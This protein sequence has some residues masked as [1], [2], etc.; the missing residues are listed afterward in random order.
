MTRAKWG[1]QVHQRFLRVR[2]Q[3]RLIQS[4]DG[5]MRRL[6]S[7]PGQPMPEVGVNT[8][9][10]LQPPGPGHALH[11]R[12]HQDQQDD[13]VQPRSFSGGNF[14]QAQGNMSVKDDHSI[15]RFPPGC[16]PFQPKD[17]PGRLNSMGGFILSC[18]EQRRI[19]SSYLYRPANSGG[20]NRKPFP[21][22]LLPHGPT[23]ANRRLG[24]MTRRISLPGADL[25][26]KF[27]LWIF[28]TDYGFNPG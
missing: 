4:H 24:G 25:Q 9:R 18:R 7:D 17:A 22:R 1:V 11:G 6:I 8:F 23:R 21:H 10:R 3:G 20:I 12:A 19:F 2:V 14:S 26:E 27:H 28:Y 15:N 5:H 13:Q 16:R